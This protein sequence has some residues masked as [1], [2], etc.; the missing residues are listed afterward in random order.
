MGS[1]SGVRMRAIVVRQI[2]MQ[3]SFHPWIGPEWL[4][5]GLFCHCSRSHVAKIDCWSE[6]LLQLAV[7]VPRK[8]VFRIN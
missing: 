2:G 5:N 6:F 7:R 4:L 8:S 1:R 3:L